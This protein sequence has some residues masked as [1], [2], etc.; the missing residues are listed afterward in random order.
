MNEEESLVNSFKDIAILTGMVM[1]SIIEKWNNWHC[2]GG[3][4]ALFSNAN[5]LIDIV[6]ENVLDDIGG[7]EMVLEYRKTYHS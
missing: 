6:A 5:T 1:Y 4:A 3:K 7:D 2:I